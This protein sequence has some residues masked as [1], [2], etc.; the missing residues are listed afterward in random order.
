MTQDPRERSLTQ[1]P[2]DRSM[3]QDPAPGASPKPDEAFSDNAP[4]ETLGQSSEGLSPKPVEALSD[5]DL[6]HRAR[7]LSNSVQ[8]RALGNSRYRVENVLT[9]RGVDLS[10]Q[11]LTLVRQFNQPELPSR[12][13]KVAQLPGSR[14]P[15]LLEELL[16]LA[17]LTSALATAA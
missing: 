14:G 4:W 16:G 9:G 13:L 11:E 1:D 7:Q 17:I 15:E 12:A 10:W 5:S 6:R 8:V 3:T 2:Q